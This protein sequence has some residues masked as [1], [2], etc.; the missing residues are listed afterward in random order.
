M[1]IELIS[2]SCF[3][4]SVNQITCNVTDKLSYFSSHNL[5]FHINLL[6][7]NKCKKSEAH[8]NLPMGEEMKKKKLY[9]VPFCPFSRFIDKFFI[10]KHE[11]MYNLCIIS[12]PLIL[13][14]NSVIC[15]LSSGFSVSTRTLSWGKSSSFILSGTFIPLSA[16]FLPSSIWFSFVRS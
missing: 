16:L 3:S 5:R 7:S 14:V 15:A 13:W 6:L 1:L 9:F 8:A 12:I 11:L 4:S 10:M 2:S